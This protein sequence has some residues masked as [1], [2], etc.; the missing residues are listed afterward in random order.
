MPMSIFSTYSTGENRVTSSILAVLKSLSLQIT[1]P[2]LGAIMEISEFELMTFQNQPK[3]KNG[4]VPDAVIFSSIKMLLETKIVKNAVSKEQLVRHL[5]GLDGNEITKI[6]LVLTPDQIEPK[7]ISE[8][9]DERVVWSSFEDLYQAIENILN[10]TKL[11]IS[12]REEFLLK[13]LQSFFLEE[14]LLPSEN[15]VLII[16]AKNA[17]PDYEMVSAYVCQAERSFQAATHLAFYTKGTIK[18]HVPKILK[19]YESEE[20]T[21]RQPNDPLESIVNTLLIEGRRKEGKYYKVITLSSIND[22]QTII[23]D[24][25][26]I[27]DKTDKSGAI[28][29]FVQNQTYVSLKSLK[30]AQKTSDLTKGNA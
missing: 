6:L 26:I 25:E 22:S 27:N 3:S 23:L 12:E 4:S 2:L 13:N 14:G 21:N 28:T 29:A 19:I 1:E 10:E 16:P 15:N 9:N 5:S 7:E 11:V 8:I 17:W 20:F 30:S 18:K 24:N